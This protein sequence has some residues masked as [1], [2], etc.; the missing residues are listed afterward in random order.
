M[1]DLSNL[2]LKGLLHYFQ[3][4][5]ILGLSNYELDFSIPYMVTFF[6]NIIGEPVQSLK[7]A[8]DCATNFNSE[9]PVIYIRSIWSLT[10]PFMYLLSVGTVYGILI[11]L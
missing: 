8:F 5:T 3:I 7:N 1:T 11:K 10:I 4:I 2:V 9:I 6:P